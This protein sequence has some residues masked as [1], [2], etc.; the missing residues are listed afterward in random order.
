MDASGGTR[1]KLERGGLWVFFSLKSV[2]GE[3]G[4]YGGKEVYALAAAR[5]GVRT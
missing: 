4:T 2:Y 5:K 3:L 1:D